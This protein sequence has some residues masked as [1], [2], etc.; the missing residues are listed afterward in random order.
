M[1]KQYC[2]SVITLMLSFCCWKPFKVVLDLTH[3]KFD[4]S[5]YTGNWRTDPMGN[6]KGGE[7]YSVYFKNNSYTC[8]GF[9]QGARKI[10]SGK[11]SNANPADNLIS[12]WG[13]PCVFDG[14]G[15]LYDPKYGLIGHLEKSN[16][17]MSSTPSRPNNKSGA[18]SVG[19]KKQGHF[20]CYGR[21]RYPRQWKN[22]ASCNNSGCNFGKKH[23]L[24]QCLELADRKGA[25]EVIYGVGSNRKNE[26]WLQTSCGN[27]R[28]D[29]RFINYMK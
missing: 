18:Q 16:G 9:N 13:F 12:L 29:H 11:Y 2:M 25:K 26:C 3:N 1:K 28:A 21:A 17:M 7:T 8:K 27:K 20:A 10:V 5:V 6:L 24:K 15:R 14:K 19:Y 4:D 23:S 22:E